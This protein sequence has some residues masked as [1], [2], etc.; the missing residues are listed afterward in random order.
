LGFDGV[1]K[2]MTVR[3]EMYMATTATV[4][5]SSAA[6]LSLEKSLSSCT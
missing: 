4:I 3:E 1:L 6:L 5:A 2:D